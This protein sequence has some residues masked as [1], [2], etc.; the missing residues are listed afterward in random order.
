[1][2]KQAFLDP[3]R[4]EI[5]ARFLCEA[6]NEDPDE[7]AGLANSPIRPALKWEIAAHEIRKQELLIHAIEV[8]EKS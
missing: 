2:S 4:L 8:G 6:R 1:M 7:A 3:I 5:A